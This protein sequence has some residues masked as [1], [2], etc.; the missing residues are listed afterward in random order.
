MNQIEELLTRGV[1]EVIDKK[2]L[3]EALRGKKK[4]RVKLG[5]DSNK[6]DLHIGHAVPLKKLRDFQDAGHIVVVI[7]GDYTAQLGDPSER[8]EARKIIDHKET[9]KNA[10]LFLKQIFK[11]L[12]KSKTKVRRNSEW[13][14]S[15]GF[16]KIIE[17]LSFSTINQ[18]LAHETFHKRL[19][20]GLPLYTQEIIYP[21]MQGY[22]SVM[23]KSD[24]EF[25]AM[26]QKFNVLMGRAMQKAHGQP[27]QD[28]I[29]FP[30][31]T[32]TDGH[33]KMSKSLGNTINLT[34]EPND[35]FGKVMSIPDNLIKEYFT[36]ATRLAFEEI[37]DVMKLPN[38]RDQKLILAY[39]ITS[40]YH[41]GKK[42]EEAR[43]SFISQFS[44]GELPNDIPVKIIS[45]QAMPFSGTLFS[46]GLVSSKSEGRRLIDQGGVKINGK[47]VKEDEVVEIGFDEMLIQVGKR[48]FIK[49]KR[50]K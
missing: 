22:D 12:D 4:L 29:L 46:V 1:E 28:V 45:G 47:V 24:V 43:E 35:M 31:L 30:Y 21:I 48:R 23:V 5:L 38:P 2:H 36:L 3:E 20:E 41:G 11:I 8:T 39:E 42:A 25:G 14:K 27:E 10:D 6:P 19:D 40:L 44:K 18:L 7:L 37:N 50:Q 13:F 26:D 34:D 49:V 32:G 17:L 15:F 9:K 16:R 33:M